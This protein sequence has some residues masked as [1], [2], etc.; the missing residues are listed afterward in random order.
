MVPEMEP[1]EEDGSAK[2]GPGYRVS[3]SMLV[4]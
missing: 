3:G 2:E 4:V 1:F